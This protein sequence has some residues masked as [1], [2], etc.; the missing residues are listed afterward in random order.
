MD[1]VER[2]TPKRRISGY[3][4]FEKTPEDTFEWSWA[5]HERVYVNPPYGNTDTGRAF[6]DK[7]VQEAKA[8]CHMI[9]CVPANTGTKFFQA[10][11]RYGVVKFCSPRVH[12]ID[13]ETGLEVPH[14]M[15]DTALVYFNPDT[16]ESLSVFCS[17]TRGI[18]MQ[19]MRSM[20]KKLDTRVA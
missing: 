20:Q 17:D 9:I 5:A 16:E 2:W 13:Y 4:T 11:M 14:V 10:C 12:F 19:K 7:I 8:G 3:D 15:H 6:K 18:T 1:A